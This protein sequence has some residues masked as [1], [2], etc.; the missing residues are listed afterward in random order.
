M[1]TSAKA[2]GAL[3]FIF[4]TLFLDVM[5]LGIIIP[6]FPKLIERLIHG[7]LSAASRWSGLLIFVYAMAQ[8]IFAPVLGN[9]SDRYGR[10]PVLL[11]SLLGFG[12]DYI[13]M[14]FA[15]T[16]GWLFVS[17]LLAGITGASFTTASAYIADIS[18]PEKRAQNF[19]L[20]GAAF[21]LGFIFGPVI[22]GVL[23]RFGDKIPFLT[24]AS[25]T[26]LN[27]LYGFFILP[28]SLPAA[29]RR[30]F[31][32]KRANP[33]GAL[34]QLKKYPAVYGLLLTLIT[35]YMASTGI[36]STWTYYCMAKFNWNETWVG[37]SLGFSGIMTAFV[38]LVV[39]RIALPKLGQVKS[40]YLGLSI[41]SI[42]LFLL[43][44]A[45]E[46]WM[47]FAILVPYAFGNIAG[48]ALSSFITGQVPPNE[49]GELQG[50]LTS[51]M[52]AT[53]IISPLVMTNLFAYFTQKGTPVQFPG[54]PFVLCSILVAI[55]LFFARRSMGR[56]NA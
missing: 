38:Q 46:G 18:T 15:P 26:L 31:D 11:S 23:V 32:W 4:F 37:Y 54:A 56:V 45:G 39:I 19:G 13:F 28:E 53:G 10:R 6:V 27:V 41:I 50:A 48:P 36:Q 34:M 17:R 52:S 43:G 35:F 47:L 22:G 55:G 42:G 33:V 49:Q 5:G 40:V 25:L 7:D 9:L 12:L 30:P 1:E 29:N 16:I 51:L 14:A 2:R 21:G 3:G 44:M 8:F 24:A 20:I